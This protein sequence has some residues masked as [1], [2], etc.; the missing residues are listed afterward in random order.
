MNGNHQQILPNNSVLKTCA[1]L[2]FM[3][4]RLM[5]GLLITP[6]LAFGYPPPLH[7]SSGGTA[8]L[9]IENDTFGGEDR[10]YSNG[11]RLS[12]ISDPLSISY[13]DSLANMTGIL[14]WS[15]LE[16]SS[17][18]RYRYGLSVTQLIFT[19]ADFRAYDQPEGER[20]YAGWLAMGFSLHAQVE[21]VLNSMEFTLG[22][23]GPNSFAKDAQDAIHEMRNTYKF[24]GWNEQIPNEITA[25]VSFIQKRR[26]DINSMDCRSFSMDGIL[27]W[28]QRLGTFRTATHLGAMLRG[29][30]HLAPDFS[31]LRLSETAYAHRNA[32]VDGSTSSDWSAYFLG[33]TVIRGVAHDATLDGPLFR[34]FETGNTR[35]PFVAEAF[36]GIG[37]AY[38]GMELSY[39]H[40]WRSKEY[41][42]QDGISE[43]G[44]V[45]LRFRF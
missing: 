11:T 33:G 4:K 35:E 15:E 29:G 42:E 41:E 9:Y 43:F 12:W 14:T 17:E 20:R 26:M 28:G 39:V 3:I 6:V 16:N 37:L 13:F 1:G 45:G 36:F 27:E 8:S 22:T 32:R 2:S 44:S 18:V 40:T 10:D 21:N 30:F 5:S 23:I 34:D 24:N 38:R 25:D 7:Q 19:P 31:D